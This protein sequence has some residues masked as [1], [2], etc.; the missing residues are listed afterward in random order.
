MI[1]L[2]GCGA[3]SW[4]AEKAGV[5]SH[6]ASHELQVLSKELSTLENYSL[7]LVILRVLTVYLYN[8]MNTI[9]HLSGVRDN[10]Y[11]MWKVL[12]S[13]LNDLLVTSFPLCE[14]LWA[15]YLSSSSFYGRVRSLR[16]RLNCLVQPVNGIAEFIIPESLMSQPN[17][18]FSFSLSFLFFSPLTKLPSES[19]AWDG[20]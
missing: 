18:S 7:R 17:S 2:G 20:F 14:N 11:I 9:W 12:N 4:E 16:I 19:E 5:E 6:L 8:T 15:K 13:V 1:H 3:W 10:I